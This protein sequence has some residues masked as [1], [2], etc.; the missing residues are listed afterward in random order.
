MDTISIELADNWLKKIFSMRRS[1]LPGGGK[2]DAKPVYICTLLYLIY[3]G[4]IRENKFYFDSELIDSYN[5]MFIKLSKRRRQELNLPFYHL[6]TEDYYF[7]SWNE[8][9]GKIHNKSCT[10]TSSFLKRNVNYAFFLEELWN[11]IKNRNY[12]IYF[13]QKI[14]ENYFPQKTF[15]FGEVVD[16][17][18]NYF[19]SET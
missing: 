19:A 16:M 3:H 7:I 5:T 2:A 11:L 12:N 6:S 1:G 13:L 8:I 17:Q 9:Y 10:P 15:R 14:I 4:V 18:D